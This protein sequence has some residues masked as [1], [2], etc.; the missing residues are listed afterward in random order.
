MMLRTV[1]SSLLDHRWAG[2]WGPRAAGFIGGQRVSGHCRDRDDACAVAS[3]TLASVIAAGFSLTGSGAVDCE[4]VRSVLV[5]QPVNTGSS[6]AYV[7]VGVVIVWLSRGDRGWRTR[8]LVLAGC[9]I[10]VGLGSVAFHGPRP[11]GAQLMHD[12]PIVWLVGLMILHDVTLILPRFQQVL[13][14]FGAGALV[15]TALALVVPGTVAVVAVVLVA[16]LVLVE[17]VV[18]RRGLRPQETHEQRRVLATLLL[19]VV[20]A[21]ALWVL[22]RDGSPVCD[23]DSVVQLHAVWHCASALA[24]GIWWWLALSPGATLDG[25]QGIDQGS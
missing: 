23:P 11:A 6:F 8:S 13:P 10:A 12:L 22:G 16:V 15:M 9:L 14:V 1:M 4:A 18:S 7:V 25:L 2:P 19:V 5:G 3:S 17:V 21:A 20:V 24:F